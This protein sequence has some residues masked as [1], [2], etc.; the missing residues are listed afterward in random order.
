MFDFIPFFLL[1]STTR[2]NLLKRLT[3]P[4]ILIS[5]K[6][7]RLTGTRKRNWK[8]RKRRP[9]L[10]HKKTTMTTKVAAGSSYE[11][12]TQPAQ[13]RPVEEE[14]GETPEIDEQEAAVVT[15]EA[16]DLAQAL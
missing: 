10:S 6:S 13:A 3:L 14:V 7:L 4:L 15:A 11:G 9:S 16:G 2:I 12:L 5:R 1:F 8:K